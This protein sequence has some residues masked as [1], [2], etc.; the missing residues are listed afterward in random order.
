[1]ARLEDLLLVLTLKRHSIIDVLVTD[2]NFLDRF[3]FAHWV[4]V[5][6][7]DIAVLLLGSSLWL[8]HV[9][10][11]GCHLLDVIRTD[12]GDLERWHL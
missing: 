7:D 5:F 12:V 4:D 6:L 1:M 11:L 2:L 9:G 8:H 10:Q 3:V